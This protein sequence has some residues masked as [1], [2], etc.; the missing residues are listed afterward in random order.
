MS[1]FLSPNKGLWEGEE[2]E[3]EE[4]EEGERSSQGMDSCMDT[5][6]WY[7]FCT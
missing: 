7:D 3:G 4:E 6:L 1:Y 2:N 5:S